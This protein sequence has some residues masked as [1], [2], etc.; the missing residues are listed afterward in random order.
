ME[1]SVEGTSEVCE[2]FR[3]L[4]VRLGR[5]LNRADCEGLMYVHKIPKERDKEDVG[6]HTLSKMEA[7][8]YFEPLRPDKLQEILSK[9]GRK[10]L[11]HD[12]KEV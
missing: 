4:L 7:M 8:G 11:A 9:I 1:E 6:L 2:E 3:Y 10:D 12:I 5:Q